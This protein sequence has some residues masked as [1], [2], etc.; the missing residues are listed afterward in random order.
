VIA[1]GMSKENTQ[2]AVMNIKRFLK[3]E[4]IRGVVNREVEMMVS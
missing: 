1:A 4:A 3:G 2:L